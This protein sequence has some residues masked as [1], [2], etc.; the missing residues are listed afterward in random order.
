MGIF[1]IIQAFSAG[2]PEKIAFKTCGN[3]YRANIDR[4]FL[5]AIFGSFL[6]REQ[7]RVENND[8]NETYSIIRWGFQRRS[9]LF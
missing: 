6:E 2:K 4:R 5:Y 8:G 1:G 7:Y 3:I 9:N